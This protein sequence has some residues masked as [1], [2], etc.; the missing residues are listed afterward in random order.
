MAWGTAAQLP[1]LLEIRFLLA[2]DA[3]TNKQ[4]RKTY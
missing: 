3:P 1:E 2:V 4:K